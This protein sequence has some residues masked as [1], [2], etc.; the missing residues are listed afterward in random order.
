MIPTPLKAENNKYGFVNEL[1]EFIISPHYEK[2][3]PFEG[4]GNQ[5]YA[6]VQRGKDDFSVI[7]QKGISVWKKYSK[8]IEFIKEV[9]IY[10][11]FYDNGKYGL[12]RIEGNLV[13]DFIEE[14]RNEWGEFFSYTPTYAR[15]FNIFQSQQYSNRIYLELGLVGGSVIFSLIK[16]TWNCIIP[17]CNSLKFIPQGES[18]YFLCLGEE[19]ASRKVES[20]TQWYYL[21][22]ADG[23]KLLSVDKGFFLEKNEIITKLSEIERIQL[24]G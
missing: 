8:R 19:V 4:S 21:Y 15:C 7:N 5:K 24:I 2:V 11:E 6:I 23:K 14:K 1:G 17:F 3:F 13:L 16:S 12:Y 10:K 22:D 9:G 18:D 20:P